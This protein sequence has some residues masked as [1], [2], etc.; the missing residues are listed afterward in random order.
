MAKLLKLHEQVYTALGNWLKNDLANLPS[1][2]R[3]WDAFRNVGNLNESAAHE[4]IRFGTFPMVF[5]ED[6]GTAM[7]LFNPGKPNT[8]S[9]DKKLVERFQQ[10][11]QHP[12]VRELIERKVLHEMVHWTYG[13]AQNEKD[14]AGG[15]TEKGYDFEAAAYDHAA[16]TVTASPT[17][18]PA[19]TPAPPTPTPTGVAPTAPAPVM[20]PHP[21][22][23]A[24][25]P[26]PKARIFVPAEL[27]R[28]SRRYESNGKP[29]AIGRD[30][31]GG[32]S[33]GLYQISSRQGT[34]RK[35]LD[36][37][38]RHPNYAPFAAR[39]EKAGGDAAARS[40]SIAFHDSWKTQANDGIFRDA[41]HHFIKET[42]YDPYLANLLTRGIDVHNRSKTLNDVAWS[43]AVQHGPG[44]T[45]IFTKPW[46]RL[47][48]QEQLS[49]GQVI[50]AVYH[51]RSRV[52]V[53]FASSNAS[54]RAAVLKRFEAERAAALAMLQTE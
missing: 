47:S 18:V 35:F 9:I 41:Q 4:A 42:H 38:G 23:A 16:P 26:A 53:Y 27:G 20:P 3:V 30:T 19:P 50:N 33:Y 29:G 7:G 5:V 2:P 1:K 6:L 13:G 36:F 45:E 37:L 22:A 34:M 8:I 54:E 25:A 48:P 40:G 46:A 51:E 52:D 21:A 14:A 24:A 28:L 15:F 17:P 49:D 10:Q 32:W 43:I 12:Q 31:N 39:L 11:P 44:R